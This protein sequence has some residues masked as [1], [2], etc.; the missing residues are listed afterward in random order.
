MPLAWIDPPNT[1]RD[2]APGDPTLLYHP[3][4]AKFYDT[5]VPDGTVNG[6]TKKGRKWTNPEPPAPFVPGPPIPPP[7][8]SV[9]ESVTPLQA[10]KALRKAGL[11]N[12]VNDFIATQSDEVQE[13]WEYCISVYRNDPLITSL[14][15]ELNLTNEQLDD[16]FR[17][18]AEIV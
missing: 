13:A 6:A 16:L 15:V 5:E 14:Q 4:I 7:P 1:V 8:P 10:R 18:A 17:S 11:L 2:V 3:D 12:T 9:P